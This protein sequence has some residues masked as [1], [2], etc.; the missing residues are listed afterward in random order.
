MIEGDVFDFGLRLRRLREG[1]GMTQGELAKKLGVSKETIYRYEHNLQYPSLKTAIRLAV[2]LRTSLDYLTGIDN[3]YTI[4]L[5]GLT[6]HEQDVFQVFLKT[7]FLLINDREKGKLPD[8]SG[9]PF[10]FKKAF[11]L[12]SFTILASQNLM[13]F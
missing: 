11:L 4:R 5:S 9:F 8:K 10:L 12:S 13:R 6:P 1:R 3:E 2:L 7:F